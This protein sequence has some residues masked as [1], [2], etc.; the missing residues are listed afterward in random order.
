MP[1][2][3]TPKHPSGQQQHEGNAGVH[4]APE[5]KPRMNQP[6]KGQPHARQHS[7]GHARTKT[8]GDHEHP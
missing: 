1:N 3:P 7:S 2:Q 5:H 6:F 8:H 4:S